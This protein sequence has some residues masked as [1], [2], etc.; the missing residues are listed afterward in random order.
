MYFF[1]A[2]GKKCK[3]EIDIDEAF[4]PIYHSE[5]SQTNSEK[6]QNCEFNNLSLEPKK[7]LCFISFKEVPNH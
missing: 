7:S 4:I 2:S 3:I 5:K 6:T 1:H